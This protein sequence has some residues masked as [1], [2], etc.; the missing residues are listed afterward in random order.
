MSINIQT[1]SISRALLDVRFQVVHFLLLSRIRVLSVTM[2]GFVVF[3]SLSRS[4]FVVFFLLFALVVTRC[5]RDG[6]KPST[7]VLARIVAPP[8]APSPH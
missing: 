7:C 5:R 6:G 2:R 8:L 4:L 3:L 1:M